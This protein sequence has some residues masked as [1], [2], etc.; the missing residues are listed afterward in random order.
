MA[1]DCP[2]SDVKET[3]V[4]GETKSFIEVTDIVRKRNKILS[5]LVLG[6]D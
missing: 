6:K 4:W 3:K 2:G 1:S 5:M